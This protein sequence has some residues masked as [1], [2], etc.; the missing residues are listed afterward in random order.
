MT[1]EV[2]DPATE[3]VELSVHGIQL[4]KLDTSRALCEL[5]SELR[6]DL[7]NTQ[8]LQRHALAS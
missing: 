4:D 1:V 8:H 6:V 2:I 5:I 3:R 7:I